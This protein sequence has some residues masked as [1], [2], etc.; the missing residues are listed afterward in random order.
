MNYMN[1]VTK[2]LALVGGASLVLHEGVPRCVGLVMGLILRHPAGRA[3]FVR[4][5][6]LIL[7]GIEDG[8][9]EIKKDIDAVKVPVPEVPKI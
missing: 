8:K 2:L 6:D 1:I 5:E 7:Q 4:Y 9:A 3:A